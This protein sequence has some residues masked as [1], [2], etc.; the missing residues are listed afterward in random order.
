MIKSLH[1]MNILRLSIKYK[2]KNR[3]KLI[4]LTIIS[5]SLIN[6]LH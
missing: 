5:N 4:L 3:I 2:K 1:Y 6:N